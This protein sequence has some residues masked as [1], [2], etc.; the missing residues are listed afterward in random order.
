MNIS[1][2]LCSDQQVYADWYAQLG[3][4][5]N[6]RRRSGRVRRADAGEGAGR[7]GPAFADPAVYRGPFDKII[8]FLKVERF[9]N[10]LAI[11]ALIISNLQF[12]EQDVRRCWKRAQRTTRCAR[13]GGW[14]LTQWPEVSAYTVAR[15]CTSS[16]W[17]P[18]L[19]ADAGYQRVDQPGGE[20]KKTFALMGKTGLRKRE[21]LSARPAKTGAGDQ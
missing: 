11:R 5:A 20:G 4:I 15:C 21:E 17:P 6:S 12:L 2:V 18:R 13:R 3:R 16:R 8:T 10:D 7:N 19:R 9:D 1:V 14:T